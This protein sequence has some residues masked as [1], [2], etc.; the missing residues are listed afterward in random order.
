M[1]MPHLSAGVPS[2][3]IQVSIP[4]T[5]VGEPMARGKISLTRGIHCCLIFFISFSRPAPLNC[6][7]Y[8]RRGYMNYRCYQI[9]LRVQHFYTSRE[10]C[11]V[12]T[13][14]LSLGCRP[15][16]DWANMWHW[17]RR[18]TVFFRNTKY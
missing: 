11:E 13:G 3:C 12:F 5:S 7:E 16:G 14:Y 10:R 15:G 8:A 17:T 4:Y 2:Q 6:E 9:T 1:G 18:F